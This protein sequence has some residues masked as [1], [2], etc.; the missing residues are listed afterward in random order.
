MPLLATPRV[1]EN[2]Q[3]ESRWK[4]IQSL[5]A[6]TLRIIGA[7]IRAK[8][9]MDSSS[10]SY[11]LGS[12]DAEQ[13]RLIRQAARFAPFTER[14]FRDA[15]I[16]PGQRVLELGSGMGDVAML[17]AQIVGASGEVVGVER[18]A[19]SIARAR[20]RVEEAGL[21]NVTFL[22]C[23]ASELPGERRFDAAVG[24]LIL[25]FLP[26]PV[27]VLRGIS[28][29]VRP[30]GS[31]AFQE[32]S[33]KP[34]LALCSHMPLWSACG[35]LAVAAFEGAGANAEM[36]PGLSRLFE[37]T[38]LPT[39]AMRMEMSLGSDPESI[40]W[41]HDVVQSLWPQVERLR[42]PAEK[43]GDLGTLVERLQREAALS[44]TAAPCVAL[45]GAWCV[46]PTV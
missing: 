38:G 10:T 46:K 36:G 44:G 17:V 37:Q 45:I 27:T 41:T 16:G 29:L 26:D 34:F 39:P 43:V 11:A 24:R 9:T 12:T 13:E 21:N 35:S 31:I 4:E 23:D 32:P 42:L 8:A 22:Q 18:E 6:V 5:E 25:Q 28:R 7:S 14:L 33:W 40:R 19:R 30:G 3:A 2:T 20:R 1:A 15:G